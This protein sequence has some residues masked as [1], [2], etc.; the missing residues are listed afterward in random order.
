MDFQE[1]E[2]LGISGYVIFIMDRIAFFVDIP[3]EV[4]PFQSLNHQE[5]NLKVLVLIKSSYY[6]VPNPSTTLVWVVFFNLKG[7]ICYTKM[8]MAIHI[9]SCKG[10]KGPFN[11]D[12]DQKR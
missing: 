1:I 2:V 5:G 9:D 7:K 8:E 4:R 6:I 10:G 12:V 3:S 11:N